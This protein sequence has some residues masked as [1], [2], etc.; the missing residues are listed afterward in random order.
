MLPRTKSKF[1]ETIA[2]SIINISLDDL[3]TQFVD[4][5]A[6]NDYFE[7]TET[8]YINAFLN[9]NNKENNFSKLGKECFN[10]FRNRGFQPLKILY[11]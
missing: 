11:G 6:D 10:Y 5:L 4:Y 2:K 9:Y 8:S 3:T 1:V 7:K